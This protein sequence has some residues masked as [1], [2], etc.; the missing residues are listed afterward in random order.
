MSL[1]ANRC[2]CN[3]TSL[4]AMFLV[5]ALVEVVQALSNPDHPASAL[6]ASFG[7]ERKYC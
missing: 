7:N 4:V 5:G 2:L 3:D 6:V 1:E